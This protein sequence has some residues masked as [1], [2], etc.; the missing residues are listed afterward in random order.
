MNGLLDQ[1]YPV[2]LTGDLN[3][4][5][6]LDYTKETVGTRKG[7][8][9]PVPW[10]VSRALLGI[11]FGST[12]ERSTPIRSGTRDYRSGSPGSGSTTSTQGGGSKTLSS[13]IVGER[14]GKE[15]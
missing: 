9:E 14:G 6:S 13:R 11:G 12:Y 10:P 15:D 3:E 4:P 2:F 5:S 7:I 1:G 8:D